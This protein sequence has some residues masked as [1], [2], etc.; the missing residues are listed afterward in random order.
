MANKLSGIQLLRAV[1][2]IGVVTLHFSEQVG[3]YGHG[4]KPFLVRHGLAGL[5]ASGVDI[6]FVIS[7]FIMYYTRSTIA[8][9]TSA[10]AEF[11]RRRAI[12]IFPTYWFWTG[13]AMLVWASHLG[14]TSHHYDEAYV[15]KSLFIIPS[16]SEGKW[17][18]FLL[19][20]WT[21]TYELYFYLVFAAGLIAVPPR[22]LAA[23]AGGAIGALFLVAQ[24]PA[25]D[26]STFAH[27]AGSPLVFEFVFGILVAWVI[28][29]I[30][31]DDLQRWH[32]AGVVLI[33]A[34]IAAFLATSLVP[35]AVD[36]RAMWWGIPAMLLVAG[37]AATRFDKLY[38]SRWL[39]LLGD[40]SYSIYLSHQLPEMLLTKFVKAGKLDAL[41]SDFVSIFG[42]VVAICVG[43]AGYFM[44]E[45]PIIARLSRR[46]LA[47]DPPMAQGVFDRASR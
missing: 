12:R 34:G 18:V 6:F 1:A 28:L 45:R 9:G 21:L 36:N 44:I 10:A 37:I 15:I 26:G 11:L 47:A 40:A 7:G 33:A 27:I 35:Q 42:I 19:P 29:K 43:V 20:G 46:R 39:L 8:R 22:W 24:A 17:G 13:A 30:R 32:P 4:A 14:F 31:P 38:E 41:S 5:G 25:L 23:Y 16:V 2:A 3:L